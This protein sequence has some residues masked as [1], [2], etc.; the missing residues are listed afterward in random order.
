[1]RSICRWS[2]E[3]LPFDG[4]CS[5]SPL[6]E[7]PVGGET[8]LTAEGLEAK[9]LAYVHRHA[10]SASGDY[11]KILKGFERMRSRKERFTLT[12][13]LARPTKLINVVSQRQ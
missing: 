4:L 2:P 8:T 7:L 13:T 11:A 6:V 12:S 9:A 3:S 1:M 5:H 10:Y